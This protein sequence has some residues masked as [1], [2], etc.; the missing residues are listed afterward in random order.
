MTGSVR[1]IAILVLAL[2]VVSTG[3]LTLTT[4]S[5]LAQTLTPEQRAQLQA[6]YD[7]LQAEIAQWQSVL[8]DT[9]AKKNSLQGDVTALNAQIAKAQAEIKQ[10]G[11][12]IATLGDQIQKK[13]ATIQTLEQQLESGHESLAKLLRQKNETETMPLALLAFSSESL[14]DFF[15]D[16]DAID[17]IDRDLDAQFQAIRAT[18]EQASRERDALD[19]QKNA[20]LDAK[21]EVEVKK[22]QISDDQTQK[23]QLLAVTTNQEKTYAQVLADRKKKA[24]EIRSALFQLRDAAAIQF[25]DALTYAQAAQKTTGVEPAL[26]LAILTQESNLGQNVGQCY[27]R[28]NSTGA[29]VGKNTGTVFQK[30]MSPTRDVPPFL[31]LSDQLGFDPHQQVVSCPIGNVGYGGAMGPAQFIAST[32]KGLANRIASARGVSVANPWD[33]Q[34]AIMAMSMYLG[35]LGARSSSYTAERTAAAKYYAG[36]NWATL[37]Q[38]YAS[39]VMARVADIQKNIS[40]LADNNL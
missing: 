37:G 32:W 7:Q 18:R 29:G 1:Y 26:V 31:A 22:Q 9:R 35:D 28:D 24:D 16:A 20:Q 21:H 15:S 10:R 30:V 38:T 13:T 4:H 6:Q 11:L 33:P 12:T 25:G 34:D 40:F 5:A 36:S 17:S 8:D 3:S 19:T 14:S 27:L 23:K 39:Q 2:V